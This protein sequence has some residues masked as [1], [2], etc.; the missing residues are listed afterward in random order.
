AG[1]PCTAVEDYTGFPEMLD[2]RVKTLHPKAHGAMLGVRDNPK[3]VGAADT[4]GIKFIDLL[5]ANLYPFRETIAKPD[6]SFETAVEN[7]DIGGPAM[8]RSAAKTHKYVAVVCNPA[9]YKPVI[10][11]MKRNRGAVSDKMRR[12]LALEAFAHTGQYDAAIAMYLSK[13]FAAEESQ[14]PQYFA[15]WYVKI[16]ADLRYGENPHQRAAAY[17]LLGAAEDGLAG[18]V[19][20]HGD[21]ELSFNNYLDLAAALETVRDF[22]APTAVIIKHLNP[23]GLASAGTL[24]EAFTDAW[25]GDPISAFG[26]V[27]GFNRVVDVVTA[28]RIG[29][30]DYLKEA[31]IPRYRRE[32]G[33]EDSE[34]IGAFV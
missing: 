4:H 7:I 30:T 26:S 23:C 12:E 18:A 32:S 20:L 34:I 33:D 15:P 6:V 17:K 10:A 9:R 25:V 3:H 21:K 1:I 13:Q 8:L 14:L 27:M 16:D 31:V 11:E 24:A 19:K 5:V 29:N 28:R 22:T 2:G